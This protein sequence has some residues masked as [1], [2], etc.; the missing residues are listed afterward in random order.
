MGY[1]IAGDEEVLAAIEEALQRQPMVDSQA[2][3]GE[4]VRT[5]LHE[6]DPD[7]RVS[8]E[9]VRRLALE[10]ELARVRVRT[11]T[12][13]EPAREE[14]PVCGTELEQVENRTLEGGRTV[15]GTACPECPYGTGSRHEVPL[16]YEFIREDDGEAGPDEKGPF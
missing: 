11:G 7:L 12:T 13:G 4:R 16:R 5:V 1:A 2:E 9:R 10:H 14:C 8:D 15:V 3:F 6:E